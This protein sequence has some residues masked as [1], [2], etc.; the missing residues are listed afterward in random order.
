MFTLKRTQIKKALVFLVLFIVTGVIAYQLGKQK[1]ASSNI[2]PKPSQQ[3]EGV[4]NCPYKV[5]GGI[6]KEYVS[7]QNEVKVLGKPQFVDSPQTVKLNK[8]FDRQE[9]EKDLYK[10]S[11]DKGWDSREFDVDE[12]KKDETI[13]SASVAMTKQPHIAMVV[14]DGNIIFEAGGANIWIV[15]VYGGQGFL[16]SETVDWNIGE[17]K[18]TRYVYKDDGFMPVWTQKACWVDFE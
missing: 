3:E 11:T 12:D 4:F 5:N 10:L 15:E 7:S 9:F 14:K 8:A 17:E 6:Y 1:S 2:S 16:L 13:I 18:R